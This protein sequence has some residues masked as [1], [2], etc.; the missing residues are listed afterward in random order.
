MKINIL[1]RGSNCSLF[2]P[3]PMGNIV[4]Y[5]INIPLVLEDF[6]Q[7]NMKIG[8][9]KWPRNFWNYAWLKSALCLAILLVLVRPIIPE[10]I[11]RVDPL[12]LLAATLRT[13]QRAGCDFEAL[14]LSC[15]RGTSISIQLAQYG[16]AGDLTDHSLCPITQDVFTA[17][18]SVTK[19]VNRMGTEIEVKPAEMCNLNGLQYSLLQTVVDHCQ[20]KQHCKFATNS[21]MQSIKTTCASV[22]KFIEISYQCRPYEFRSKVACEND[23]M[24]LMCNPYSRL[25]I[26][27]ASFGHL[28]QGNV[29]CRPSTNS[30]FNR[31]SLANS[32]CMASYATETTMQICHG[33]RRCTVV[34]DTATFGRPCIADF[35]LHLKVVYTCIPRKVLKDRFE[36]VPAPDEPKQSELY[37]DLN[38]IYDEDQFYKESEAIPPTPKLQGADGEMSSNE[39]VHK[40]GPSLSNSNVP[41]VSIQD[42]SSL[43]ENLLL[44]VGLMNRIKGS[45][46]RKFIH[47]TENVS[48]LHKNATKMPK[49]GDFSTQKPS[50][51]IENKSFNRKKCV[52]IDDWGTIGLNCTS[53]DMEIEHVEVFGFLSN[54]I[55]SFIYIKK[56]QEQFYLYLIISVAAGLVLIL[57][58]LMGRIIVQK[59]YGDCETHL[60]NAECSETVENVSGVIKK[61]RPKE[62]HEINGAKP[63]EHMRDYSCKMDH[64]STL[65]CQRPLPSLLFRDETPENYR[66]D[67]AK[68]T[69]PPKPSVTATTT[70]IAS[71]L[72][73]KAILKTSGTHVMSP[74]KTASPS[75]ETTMTPRNINPQ[76]RFHTPTPMEIRRVPQPHYF[77]NSLKDGGVY[78]DNAVPQATLDGTAHQ[79]YA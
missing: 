54:W 8:S 69:K 43:K 25:A 37:L 60:S 73:K 32:S 15:P 3:L 63:Q 27:S 57:S 30:D 26:Y 49:E 75:F 23:T 40:E 33:R 58:I 9:Y 74:T 79:F 5:Q 31:M 39:K 76:E 34:A 21:K 6:L 62:H 71:H 53:E 19:A 35:Q 48:T 61:N 47:E 72:H 68:T 36:T 56:H 55:E 1:P 22:P 65:K 44:S 14:L 46:S 2:G 64:D 67:S 18:E 45:I 10:V 50:N 20:K 4:K 11:T 38:E 17:S 70:L 7:K 66:Y 16:R 51:I 42:K 13:H 59:R 52:N 77:L 78:Y 24:P 41:A 12:A 29:M 28:Q